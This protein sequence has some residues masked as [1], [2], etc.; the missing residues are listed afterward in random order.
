MVHDVARDSL[1]DVVGVS[2]AF[3]ANRAT[4]WAVRDVSLKVSAGEVVTLLGPNGAGKTTLMRMIATLLTPSEGTIWVSGHNVVT[5]SHEARR[6]LS[7]VLGGDRGFYLRASA[8]E[9]L[10]Y[11]A[12]LAGVPLRQRHS[13]V[14]DVLSD[15]GLAARAHEKVETFSRGMRQRLHI[16]RSL[17]TNPPLLL[18][19]EP[20]IGLDP[21]SAHT[22]RRLIKELRSSGRAILLTTHYLHEAEDLSDR[23]VVIIDGRIEAEG[24]VQEIAQAGGLGLVTAFSILSEPDH[25]LSTLEALPEVRN[26]RS[27]QFGGRRLVTV[28]WDSPTPNLARLWESTSTLNVEAP[29]TREPTLEEGYL[30]LVG[31]H[32]DT[33][34]AGR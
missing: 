29:T 8:A 30:A 9:N 26:V 14:R 6:N 1:L 17:L 5:H 20:T 4:L 32:R 10:I 11:F 16:A 34:E 31:R 23:S 7:L 24:S 33:T 27:E 19:D 12:S 18:L 25:L 22:L 2:R 15:F 21:E 13:R 3:T 28:G